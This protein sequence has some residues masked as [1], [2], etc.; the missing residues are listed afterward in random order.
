MAIVKCWELGV[1]KK[2]IHPFERSILL[3]RCIKGKY[4]Q[5]AQWYPQSWDMFPSKFLCVINDFMCRFGSHDF[6]QN[7]PW[8]LKTPEEFTPLD[9]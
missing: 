6:I 8:N 4:N 5:Q 2:Y 1:E 7:G 3:P 9:E